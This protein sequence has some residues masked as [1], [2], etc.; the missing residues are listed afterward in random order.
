[1]GKQHK[2]GSS[3]RRPPSG[4][5]VRS[6][7]KDSASARADGGGAAQSVGSWVYAKR[8][9]LAF[10][11][12]FAVLMGAFYSVTFLDYVNLKVLP[13]YM[14]F[15]AQASVVVL[16][17][18]GENARTVDT[19][20]VSDRFSVNIQ[21]GCDAIDPTLLFLS[22]VLAFPASMASKLP[23][24]LV[25]TVALALMNLMRIVTLF[26]A[27]IYYPRWFEVMHVDVWQTVFVVVSLTFWIIWAWWATK[28]KVK[29]AHVSAQAN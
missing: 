19:S 21:H 4:A 22:A 1:M 3:G 29:K 24:L 14:R 9:V 18:F 28:P 5:A 16:N 27:G 25:G 26:Y 11:V 2:A 23:G 17:I 7:R 12:L 8:P 10:V 13:A 20:V 15:N 6:G